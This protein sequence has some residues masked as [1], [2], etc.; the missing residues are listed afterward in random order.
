MSGVLGAND[1][2]NS[3]HRKLNL[4]ILVRQAFNPLTSVRDKYGPRSG[5]LLASLSTRILSFL[6]IVGRTMPVRTVAPEGLV[7][8]E[9][10]A[11]AQ[12]TLSLNVAVLALG[13]VCRMGTAAL[14][15]RACVIPAPGV[16]A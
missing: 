12:P 8:L 7:A 6:A 13:G 1:R 15:Q 5:G 9:V 11:I 10:G 2:G 16:N 14:L 4:V 3:I